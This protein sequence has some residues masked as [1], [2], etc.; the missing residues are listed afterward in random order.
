MKTLRAPLLLFALPAVLVAFAATRHGELLLARDALADGELWRLWTGHWVHL[1]AS[2]L[3]WNLGV[4]VIAGAGLDR[5]R[6]GLLW[7]HTLIVAPFLSC[8]I[9]VL[10]P[11][12]QS[13]GGLS[14]LATSVV[15]MLALENFRASGPARW[16]WGGALALVAAKITTEALGNTTGFTRYDSTA[17]RTAWSAHAAGALAAVIHQ[18]LMRLRGGGAPVKATSIS[19]CRPNPATLARHSAASPPRGRAPSGSVPR[20]TRPQAPSA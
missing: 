14:G 17:V 2:H 10:E 11:G 8:A 18:G 4:L 15:V 1:S 19:P 16:L 5:L 7:R 9:L 3:L 13:Y 20:S 6:P 12:L